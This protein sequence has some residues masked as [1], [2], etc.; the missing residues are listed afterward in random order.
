[1]PSVEQPEDL[2]VIDSG[3]GVPAM[4]PAAIAYGRP[5]A[6][7]TEGVTRV[8][9]DDARK[10]EADSWTSAANALLS[11]VTTRYA[12]VLDVGV[13]A[14]D[15]TEDLLHAVAT[16]TGS[17]FVQPVV[18]DAAGLIVDA[19]SVFLSRGAP[20]V[21]V[22]AEHPV[23]DLPERSTLQVGTVVARCVLI[24]LEAVDGLEPG[25][26]AEEGLA[27]ATV[28]RSPV[29][30]LAARVVDAVTE[31]PSTARSAWRGR[32]TE[33]LVSPSLSSVLDHTRFRV[34]GV[35]GTAIPGM[36]ERITSNDL[37]GGTRAARPFLLPRREGLRWAIRSGA[38]SGQAGEVWGDTY[39][40][41]DLAEALRSRGRD[42][43][44]DTRDT[45]PRA[46][47]DHLDDVTVTLRGLHVVPPNPAAFNILWVISHPEMVSVD[48]LEAYDL[49][50]AA[51]PAWARRMAERA[52]VPVLPLLQ[53]TS[54]RRFHPGPVDAAL[55]ADVLFVGKTRNVFRPIVRD[56]LEAGGELAVYGDGWEQFIDP[57]L[58]RAQFLPNDDVSAAYR[59]ARIVLNDHWDD[60]RR[61][62]FLANRLFDAVA[63]GARV[64]S[65]DIE[66][67][68]IFGGAV[69][70][71]TDV[72]Q[73][74]HLLHDEEGWPDEDAMVHIAAQIAREHSFEARADQLIQAVEERRSRSW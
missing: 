33:D 56:V 32:S 9:V 13:D 50:F 30:A 64:V 5:A 15:G 48:E 58:V 23:A 65:D 66:G 62:G 12:F 68:D 34:A 47:S 41:E 71:Y 31:V 69:R 70:S 57:S 17:A 45:A 3:E 2:P 42:V 29:V 49:V 40:A 11:T 26:S 27:R 4:E 39:F 18:T 38:P 28:T 37:L 22:L 63:S 54:P 1:M 6:P 20:P 72:G 51:G 53:A 10:P 73:L 8:V 59:S 36:T 67:L 43:V 7:L 44:V 24:D 61:E 14:P 25:Y 52:S 46:A 19:G 35:A 74:A 16:E 21:R 55:A 60:M